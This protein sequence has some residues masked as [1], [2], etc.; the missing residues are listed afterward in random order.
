MTLWPVAFW[1]LRSAK[2]SSCFRARRRVLRVASP[3]LPPAPP[4]G[5]RRFSLSAFCFAS[6]TSPET[7]YGP[8]FVTT[9][10]A[11]ALFMRFSYQFKECRRPANLRG[12]RLMVNEHPGNHNQAA[13][14]F[15]AAHL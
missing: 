7:R 9:T 13:A 2:A 11:R 4:F 15:P 10:R 5:G 6:G 12:L 14:P 1:F 8:S 3:H